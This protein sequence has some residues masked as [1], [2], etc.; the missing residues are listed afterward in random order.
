MLSKAHFCWYTRR[1]Q[2][3]TMCTIKAA[4]LAEPA[5]HLQ[6]YIFYIYTYTYVGRNKTFFSPVPHSSYLQY[7]HEAFIYLCTGPVHSARGPSGSAN[8]ILFNFAPLEKRPFVQ[9]FLRNFFMFFFCFLL[10]LLVAFS[11]FFSIQ[12]LKKKIK[13][14]IQTQCWT[15]CV[16]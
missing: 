15:F 12:F 4:L 6:I 7:L 8:K 13:K 2:L 9:I 10:L 5:V 16:V 14:K 1:A 11:T 3:P